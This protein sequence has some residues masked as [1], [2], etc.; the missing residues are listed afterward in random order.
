VARAYEVL[1]DPARR[2]DYDRARAGLPGAGIRI[3]VRRW[4]AERNGAPSVDS[5]QAP[6]GPPEEVDLTISL[7]ESLTGTVAKVRVPAAVVCPGCSGTGERSGGSCPACGG[8]G[9]HQRRSGSITINRLCPD[10]GG[11]GARPSR[12]CG[13]CAGRGWTDKPRELTVRVPPGVADGTRLRLRAA[14]GQAAG[15]ARVRLA[16]DPWFSREGRDLV[17]RLPLNL[18]EAALGTALT[19]ALPD[20]PA[21]VSVPAGTRPGDR[22]RLPGRGVPGPERGDLVLAVEVVV[23]EDPSPEERAALEALA[24]VAD[25]P[26]KRWPAAANPEEDGW[27]PT[28]GSD[29]Q[30]EP[31]KERS[32]NNVD[33]AI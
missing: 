26:R 1:G 27:A 33:D 24:A 13:D 8:E 28:G 19:M 3:P 4:A 29:T 9:R 17:L 31:D 21:Q 22:L 10:C 12:A 30:E 16:P 7:A 32:N 15:L 6:M 25:D 2:A 20:G 11:S 5:S 14:S 23:P 18:A